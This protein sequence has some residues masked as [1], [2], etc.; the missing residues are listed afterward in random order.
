MGKKK[1]RKGNKTP[2]SHLDFFCHVD[3]TAV[4]FLYKKDIRTAGHL[5]VSNA[6]M[7]DKLRYEVAGSSHAHQFLLS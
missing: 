3:Q 4:H 7:E 2:I 1:K 5:Y 6:H